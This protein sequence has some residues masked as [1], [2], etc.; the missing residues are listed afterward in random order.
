MAALW[1]LIYCFGSLG[2]PKTEQGRQ[3]WNYFVAGLIALDLVAGQWSLIPTIE[4][5]LFSPPAPGIVLNADQ[6]V[7]LSY[8]DEYNLK[9]QR[10]FRI[11]DFNPVENWGNL[12]KV[13]LPNINLLAKTDYVNNFDPLLPGRYANFINYLDQLKPEDRTEFLKL[14]N[15]GFT[16]SIDPTI[17][18]GVRFEPVAGQGRFQW[19]NCV[20]FVKDEEESWSVTKEQISN[21]GKGVII[22]EGAGTNS[23]APCSQGGKINIQVTKTTPQSVSISIDTEKRGWLLM[24][25]T[26][27]PGW[28][29][30]VDGIPVNIYRADYL[31]G[32]IPVES[33]QHKVEIQYRPV[34]IIIGLW[35]SGIGWVI[36]IIFILINVIRNSFRNKL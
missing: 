9:F 12:W 6:R 11:D 3:R 13:L 33:G 1:G 32:G 17:Q 26:W 36:T 15:V 21:L 8:Q 35:V 14:I 4:P 19:D 7:Y 27:Y 16:E 23:A 31:L 28:I 10:F 30:T 34:S 2:L 22:I 5:S 20:L 25:D 18:A 24:A 29:A